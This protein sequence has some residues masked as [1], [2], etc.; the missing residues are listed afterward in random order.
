MRDTCSTEGVRLRLRMDRVEVV[1][2]AHRHHEPQVVGVLQ[3]FRRSC[4]RA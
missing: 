3:C 4:R 2:V 1:V